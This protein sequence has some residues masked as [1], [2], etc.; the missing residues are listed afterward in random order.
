MKRQ[1]NESL[2]F[3]NQECFGAMNWFL[4]SAT[5]FQFNLSASFKRNLIRQINSQF[6]IS[7]LQLIHEIWWIKLNE[8]N[9]TEC[10]MELRIAGIHF[11]G[12]YWLVAF[13]AAALIFNFIQFA[14]VYF[15]NGNEINFSNLLKFRLISS[16]QASQ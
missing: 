3:W 2:D 12:A 8:I 10:W 4:K 11:I 14:L 15:I 16:N 5:N 6:S 1:L 9:Q 13:I 7:L